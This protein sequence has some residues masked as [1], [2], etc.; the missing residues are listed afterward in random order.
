MSIE[1][2][3]KA[4]HLAV[5]PAIIRHHENKIKKSLRRERQV[6][7]LDLQSFDWKD[8][9]WRRYYDAH[10][11]LWKL[12]RHR[13]YDVRL[14]AR[15]T[16]LARA[17][18]DNMPYKAVEANRKR[19]IKE[20]FEFR[21]IVIPRV[22]DMVNKYH[23]RQHHITV[24]EEFVNRWNK[25]L[26]EK[27]TICKWLDVEPNLVGYKYNRVLREYTLKRYQDRNK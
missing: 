15:A 18:L 24:K 22:I 12:Q 3:I 10:V 2:T 20:D 23:N 14:E 11:Q 13:R 5:E 17:F 16:H 27:E 7:N 8:P 9:V 6:Y 4:K 25:H 1:L 26:V 21:Y 19:D